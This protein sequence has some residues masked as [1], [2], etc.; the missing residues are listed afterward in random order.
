MSLLLLL[1]ADS[2][3]SNIHTRWRWHIQIDADNDGVY[4]YD[5]GARLVF[6][7]RIER[8]RE[9]MLELPSVGKLEFA[10]QNQD[11][12][13]D[14]WWSGSPFYPF[15]MV[16]CRIQVILDYEL[17][18][19]RIHEYVT[20]PLFSGRIAEFN[21]TAIRATGASGT[22]PRRCR[23]VAYDG[24]YWLQR[25][26]VNLDLHE[27]ISTRDAI[28]QILDTV[29]WASIAGAFTLDASALDSSA[30]LGGLYYDNIDLGDNEGDTIPYWWTSRGEN[31]MQSIRDLVQSNFGRVQINT[32]GKFVFRAR[33]GDNRSPV[34]RIITDDVLQE[35]TVRYP[36]A[37]MANRV[38]IRANPRTLSDITDVWTCSDV[39][40]I[41]P[42]ET[43]RIFAEFSDSSDTSVPAKDILAPVAGIDFTAN[44]EHDGSG[45]DLT[46]FITI[47][48]YDYGTNAELSISNGAQST[49]YITLLKLR[50]RLIQ[51][52]DTQ[53]AEAYDAYSIEKYGEQLLS[54]DLRWQQ[55]TLFAQSL[56]DWLLTWLKD[57]PMPVVE[58]LFENRPDA[59]QLE[60]GAKVIDGTGRGTGLEFRVGKVVHEANDQGGQQ[61]LST[62]YLYRMPPEDYFTLDFSAFDE[63]AIGL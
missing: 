23:I 7:L 52:L 26:L 37:E 58:L 51:S 62:L 15:G 44:S 60:L 36:W 28:L 29:G 53:S 21:N 56:A 22:F 16:G 54:Y 41:P 61:I 13:Y 59:L 9:G 25:K 20:I 10:L 40:E 2:S 12:R 35:Y 1:K 30:R 50:G 55:S 24:W 31:A 4:E 6:P 38:Q 45:K 3:N 19:G 42:G 43:R 48:M 18:Y 63:V 39:P 8:G 34:D 17:D 33:H 32:D 14:H 5:E 46:S 47:T 57:A 11:R 27:N 49:A